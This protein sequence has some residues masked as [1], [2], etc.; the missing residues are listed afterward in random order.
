[1]EHQQ[2]SA[3]QPHHHS[4][5]DHSDGG[6]G[7]AHGHHHE[8]W[9]HQLRYLKHAPQLWKA[10]MNE[11]LVELIDPIPG[12][13]VLDIGAG[14]GPAVLSASD[15]VGDGRVFAVDPSPLMRGIM[16]MRRTS[17]DLRERVVVLKGKAED[18][19]LDSASIDAAWSINC[20]HHWGDDEKACRE[21]G[22]V[23]RPGG[24]LVLLDEQFSDPTHPRHDSYDSSRR[25]QP[26]F[27]HE[28]DTDRLARLLE[29]AGF[30]VDRAG[31]ERVDGTPVKLVWALRRSDAADSS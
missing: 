22:R 27:F 6:E 8:G 9:L 17:R 18:L 10:P 23:M 15:R 4:S 3:G 5:P 7:H 26:G 19:P 16:R 13:Q 14:M 25:G 20:V 31:D 24:R 21:L 29:E 1:M 2:E 12:E 28:V 11:A 30:S